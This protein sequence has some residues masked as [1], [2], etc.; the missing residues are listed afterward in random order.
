MGE[1]HQLLYLKAYFIL[2]SFYF[3]WFINFL[4]YSISAC[5]N[6]SDPFPL[7]LSTLLGINY[8][9]APWLKLWRPSWP[10][11]TVLK[12]FSCQEGRRVSAAIYLGV[13][14]S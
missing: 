5:A 6:P 12:H 2:Y 1:R 8:V 10:L 13:L 9:A 11:G 3:Q 7:R 4:F 14:K